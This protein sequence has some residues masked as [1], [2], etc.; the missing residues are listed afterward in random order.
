MKTRLLSLFLAALAVVFTF[1]ACGGGGGNE[2]EDGIVT[3]YDLLSG[4]K[5]LIIMGGGSKVKLYAPPGGD[6]RL[7]NWEPGEIDKGGEMINAY[8]SI[9]DGEAMPVLVYYRYNPSNRTAL[10]NITDQGGSIIIGGGDDFNPTE[11][12]GGEG[13]P[14]EPDTETGDNRYW[15]GSD[16][17]ATYAL[18][19]A[20]GGQMGGTTAGN[21]LLTVS[22][23]T[24]D[25][26]YMQC[27]YQIFSY[28][29]GEQVKSSYNSRQFAIVR[30]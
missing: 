9:N 4:R 27:G 24:F 25:F 13:H 6:N 20:L 26:N 2:T 3:N 12:G 8:V 29:E 22:R 18:L 11:P 16:S 10:L 5:A 15:V 1:S 30:Q 14:G 21:T 19:L 28:N 7:Q 23:L 17:H